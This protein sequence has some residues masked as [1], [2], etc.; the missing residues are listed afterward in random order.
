GQAI[1]ILTHSAIRMAIV[2]DGIHWNRLFVRSDGIISVTSRVDLTQRYL[3]EME[4]LVWNR[5]VSSAVD[6]QMERLCRDFSSNNVDIALVSET[7]M[8]SRHIMET[9]WWHRG[10][11]SLAENTW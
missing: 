6:P 2:T 1:D 10:S 5:M 9:E 7:R 8:P 11:Q 3:L 4:A